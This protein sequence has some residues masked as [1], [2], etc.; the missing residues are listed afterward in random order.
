MDILLAVLHYNH[1]HDCE[2]LQNLD[3]H[4][5]ISSNTTLSRMM[6]H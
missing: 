2:S 1:I 6:E 3:H 4:F 5:L